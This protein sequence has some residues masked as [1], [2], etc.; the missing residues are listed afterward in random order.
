MLRGILLFILI[1]LFSLSAFSQTQA[2]PLCDV[3]D[4]AGQTPKD[5][6]KLIGKAKRV[7]PITRNPEEMPGEFR[8]FSFTLPG[9]SSQS[10]EMLVRFYRGVAVRFVIEFPEKTDFRTPEQVLP[11]FGSKFAGLKAGQQFPNGWIWKDVWASGMNWRGISVL[12]D[13]PTPRIRAVHFTTRLS[14][15]N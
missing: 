3:S 9:D 4:L 11:L 7:T 1:Q 8:E 2:K 10:V 6:E 15:T 12:K 5:V 14:P 13:Y